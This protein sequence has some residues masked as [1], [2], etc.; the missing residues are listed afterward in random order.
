MDGRDKMFHRSL[1]LAF[2]G[3]H[4]AKVIM[5]FCRIG[6]ESKDFLQMRH[7]L[8]DLPL[9]CQIGR[10]IEMGFDVVWIQA[11]CLFK[12]SDGFGSVPLPRKRRAQIIMRDGVVPGDTD[13]SSK[14][15]GAILPV[16]ELLAG[17]KCAASRDE[18]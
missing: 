15:S 14:Q 12:V 6:R 18:A 16:M 9:I 11:H 3:K 17:D 10:E 7:R 4:D 13:R 1:K 8:S 2:L 5:G